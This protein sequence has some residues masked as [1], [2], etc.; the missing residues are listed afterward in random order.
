MCFR[1]KLAEL[2]YLLSCPAPG[3][4]ITAQGACAISSPQ[5]GE[6]GSDAGDYHCSELLRT[7][8]Q[9]GSGRMWSHSSGSL[10]A[11]T[12]TVSG[13]RVEETVQHFGTL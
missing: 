7:Q 3:A 1:S 4:G 9:S 6:D 11:G 8:A 2:K 12:L 10:T 5:D 13:T